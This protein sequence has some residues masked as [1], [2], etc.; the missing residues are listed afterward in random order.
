M[1][2]IR[3]GVFIGINNYDGAPLRGARPDAERM[4]EFFKGKYKY[5]DEYYDEAATE[6]NI[7]NYLDCVRAVFEKEKNKRQKGVFVFFFSGHGVERDGRQYIVLSDGDEVDLAL[8]ERKTRI[9]GV[10][11]IFI[12]DCC[13]VVAPGKNKTWIKIIDLTLT[14]GAVL[15]GNWWYLAARSV[16]KYIAEASKDC[17]EESGDCI[18]IASCARGQASM[19]T[20]SGG[21]FTK[22]LLSVLNSKEINSIDG[23]NRAF[24]GKFKG[25][26][27]QRPCIEI[28]LGANFSLLPSWEKTIRE[29]ERKTIRK[30]VRVN[31]WP[32]L[33]DMIS[34]VFY[35]RNINATD[36]WDLIA[37]ESPCMRG[38][39]MSIDKEKLELALSE[40]RCAVE[41]NFNIALSDFVWGKLKTPSALLNFLENGVLPEEEVSDKKPRRGAKRENDKTQRKT[42]NKAKRKELRRDEQNDEQKSKKKRNLPKRGS[43]SF[44][45]EIESVGIRSGYVFVS[46]T[47]QGCDLNRGDVIEVV[48]GDTK[49]RTKIE[50]IESVRRGIVQSADV[51]EKIECWF[52][53]TSKMHISKGDIMRKS[54]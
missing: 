49:I 48:H 2:T 28:S 36:S 46:G 4:S 13:R 27:K 30:K 47:V 43:K 35:H 18:T 23:F 7:T 44:F 24:A 14:I 31:I 15:T 40:L 41:G 22:E 26:D 1:N 51:G 16:G 32:L 42:G 9:P 52:K 33:V 39:G 37:L 3:A 29:K 5:V 54:K 53:K 6:E 20:P 11:R 38:K 8:V 17:S 25:E 19:D 12:L 50:G 34:S 10:D 45:M 21:V